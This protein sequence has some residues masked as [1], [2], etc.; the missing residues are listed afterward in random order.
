MI[1]FASIVSGLPS[2]IAGTVELVRTGEIRTGLALIL[3]ALVLGVTAL[4]VFVER[5]QRRIPVNYAKRQ[6]GRRVYAGQSSHLPLKLNMSGVIPP[7]FASSLILFPATIA[8]WFGTQEGLGWL[9]DSG[10]SL[11]PGQPMYTLLYICLIVFFCFFYTALVFNS[12]ETAENLKKSGAFV[13]GIRPGQA[14]GGVHRRRADAAHAVG[15]DLRRLGVPAAGVHGAQVERAVLLRR[16]VAADHRRRRDGL[17]GAVAGSHDV[18]PV[19]QPAQEGQPAQLRPRGPDSLRRAP[20]KIRA[21]V[22]KMCRNCK[23]VRRK[24]VVRVI[25]SEARHKQRQG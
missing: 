17:H 21:S 4:V 3:L 6:V 15:R 23:I 22:K 24:R 14:D 8:S 11:S 18:A 5:G 10:A 16:H 2:A 19:R 7:I 13:P 20:M 9:Q 12:R 25:C 1:I